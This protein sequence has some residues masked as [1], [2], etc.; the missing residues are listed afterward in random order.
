[1][2]SGKTTVGQILAQRFN[3]PFFDT[4]D[5]IERLTGESISSLFATE[6]EEGF[7]DIETQVLG[8]L[9]AYLSCIVATG[10]GIVLRPKNWGFLHHGLV[11]WLDLPV[12]Q[13]YTRLL[14]DST[15]PLLQGVDP[16]EKLQQLYQ[17]RQPLYSQADVQVSVGSTETPEEVADRILE[18]L[19]QILRTKETPPSVRD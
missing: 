11:V 12:E 1:M 16:L 4:D 5:L 14:A 19:P 15:R 6:G 8:Q 7:R 2:G 13:L 10:G 17:E 3:Y 9:S 18:M